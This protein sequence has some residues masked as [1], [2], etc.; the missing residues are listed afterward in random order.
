MP[1]YFTPQ[2]KKSV[3]KCGI[4]DLIKNIIKSI[5]FYLLSYSA[6]FFSEQ[7]NDIFTRETQPF[8]FWIVFI[9]IMFM[10]IYIFGFHKLILCPSFYGTVINVE[11]TH[12]LDGKKSDSPKVI[13]PS[14]NQHTGEVDVCIITVKS[15][16]GA[17]Y[18]FF[19]K[20]E[21]TMLAREYYSVG[22]AVYHNVFTK[23]PIN[24]FK[25]PPK[26]FCVRC[27]DL[28]ADFESDCPHCRIPLVNNRDNT[29]Q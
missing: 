9:V 19:F 22:D 20:R 18:K 8:W 24:C 12:I 27:G 29:K 21:N 25:A 5:I 13:F 10:P 28:C 17:K 3:N 14:D 11:N 23:Y 2:I 4:K 26:K 6:L 15:N 7:R 1:E 16:I